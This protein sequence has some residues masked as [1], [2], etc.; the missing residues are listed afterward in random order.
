MEA[1]G[2]IVVYIFIGILCGVVRAWVLCKLWLWFVVPQFHVQPL[3]LGV[4]YGLSMVAYTMHSIPSPEYKDDSTGATAA[5][6]I[7]YGI[8]IPLISLAIGWVIK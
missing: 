3:H 5:R 8:V 4:A 1:L 2:K 6:A 7:T